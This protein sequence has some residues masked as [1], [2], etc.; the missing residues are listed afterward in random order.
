MDEIAW[1]PTEDFVAATRLHRFMQKHG[2]ATVQELRAR[3][4]REPEWFWPAIM[5]D[6]GV[7]WDKP[8]DRV[9][10][11]SRGMPHTRWFEGGKINIVRNCVDRH[12]QI[13]GGKVAFYWESDGGVRIQMTYRE[14]A[15]AVT[16]TA[17]AMR[18]AGVCKGDVIGMVMPACPTAVIVMFAAMKIGAVPMQPAARLA[19]KMIARLLADANAKMVFMHDGYSYGGK[20][21]DLR[22]TIRAAARSVPK[23]RIVVVPRLG[24]PDALPHQESE[25]YADFLMR[26]EGKEPAQTLS[27]DAEDRAL[28]LFSSGTTG[29]PKAIVHVHGGMLVNT[30]KEIGYA[31]DY[32]KRDVF[33]WVTNLGWMMAPWQI[34]GVQFFGGT[35]VLYEGSP[36][37][38]TSHRLFE[39][40]DRYRVSTFGFSP[41]GIKALDQ[42]QDYSKHDLSS[43][44]ILGSTGAPIDPPTWKW[45]FEVFGQ[46]R[47]P[48]M[49]I[50]GGT[51]IMG[52]FLSPLP[53][54]PQIPSTVGGPGLGMDVIIVDG[55]GNQ[56]PVGQEGILVCR[57]PFPSMTRGFLDGDERFMQTYFE[58]WP[59]MWNH[60]DRARTDA[61]GFWYMCGRDDDL[62]NRGGVKHDPML[63]ETVVR[64][65]LHGSIVADAVVAG[66]PDESLGQ[67]IVC[68]ITL[69]NTHGQMYVD[70]GFIKAL[71]S[72]VGQKYDPSG[73][74]DEIYILSALPTTLS[75]KVPRK[76][77]VQAYLGETIAD[78]S[79]YA[80]G[81]VF[82][83]IAKLGVP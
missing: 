59:E 37:Y 30:A 62:I 6:L 36:T 11:D 41:A 60:H 64:S 75:A 46:R 14:L 42:S 82:A 13:D 5:E 3:S 22:E 25:Y 31:F 17:T 63:I 4:V 52:C 32:Q 76:K 28:I 9:L 57:K 51:E 71:R 68:F 10:D 43:L 55:Y 24:L 72:H 58:P 48:I 2:I 26:A 80:N 70:D 16:R 20:V 21:I 73:K 61:E 1:R 47:C 7:L 77:Y 15:K 8:L 49:N 34:I 74:P 81:H 56:L 67:K 65:Y 53:I 38:P 66:M 44:R 23:S 54:E 50:I 45:Y 19:P 79:S 39:M 35:H 18:E 33:F 83:D 40:I 29:K 27:L 69:K 78:A 12:A